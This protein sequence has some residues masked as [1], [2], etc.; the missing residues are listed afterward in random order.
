MD[1]LLKVFNDQAKKNEVQLGVT[2][3]AGG[4]LIS[5]ILASPENLKSILS[6]QLIASGND[7]GVMLGN[8][9]SEMGESIDPELAA[10]SETS[11]T[12]E[13]YITLKNVKIL[14]G[15][16]N[17]SAPFWRIKVESIDS[18]TIGNY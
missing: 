3:S 16:G 15:Q 10:E 6:T 5:G 7:F 17:I 12:I 9:L 1:G 14:S 4:L 13:E 2:I 18:Y 8:S 11:T